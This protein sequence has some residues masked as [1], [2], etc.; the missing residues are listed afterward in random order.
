MTDKK[1]RESRSS[2]SADS[3]DFHNIKK[4]EDKKTSEQ[5]RYDRKTLDYILRREDHT[6]LRLHE[7]LDLEKENQDPL[8]ISSSV[9]PSLTPTVLPAINTASVDSTLPSPSS[10]P[11]TPRSQTSVNN[12]PATRPSPTRLLVVRNKRSSKESEAKINRTPAVTKT[13]TETSR[14]R[15][16]GD[17]TSTMAGGIFKIPIFTGEDPENENPTRFLGRLSTRLHRSQVSIQQATCKSTLPEC[18]FYKAIQ[19]RLPRNGL[20]RQL[21]S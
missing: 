3:L 1:S 21:T 9:S 20:E 4:E 16:K 2:S 19:A 17:R 6:S 7:L 15:W 13:P 18:C 8:T 14:H 10:P 12:T 11:S 5:I